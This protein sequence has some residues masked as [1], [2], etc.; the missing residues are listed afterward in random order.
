MRPMTRRELVRLEDRTLAEIV[1]R[2]AYFSLVRFT[3][4]GIDYEI[5]VGN[6]EFDDYEGD[7]DGDQD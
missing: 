6:E 5:L 1:Q 7:N 4:G 2:G 3:R